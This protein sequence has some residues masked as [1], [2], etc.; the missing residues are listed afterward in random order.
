MLA[1]YTV[2]LHRRNSEQLGFIPQ[3]RVQEYADIG[4]IIPEYE[5]GEL[6]GYL[7]WG[8]GWPWF[9]VYQACVEY[10]LRYLAHGRSLVKEAVRIASQYRCKAIVLRCRETNKATKFW[11]TL[12]FSL[13]NTVPSGTRRGK[14]IC[15]FAFWLTDLFG[16][17]ESY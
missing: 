5:N 16:E 9:R 3:S 17:S 11:L 10:E 14:N 13:V 2:D 12:G 8:I 6:C 7:I 4:R 15:V 1:K